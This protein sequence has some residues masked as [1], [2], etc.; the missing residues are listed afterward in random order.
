MLSTKNFFFEKTYLEGLK[1]LED[2]QTL[3]YFS[4]IELLH[5]FTCRLQEKSKRAKK[6]R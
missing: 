1:K 5:K 2:E 3:E 6:R 4:N